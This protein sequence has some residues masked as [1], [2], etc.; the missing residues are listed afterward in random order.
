M[1]S[2]I[3]M[4]IMMMTMAMAIM[5]IIVLVVV[6]FVLA[7]V[8][9]GGA[10]RKT[11]TIF[12]TRC[13]GCRFSVASLARRARSCRRQSP[14]IRQKTF[15][16]FG[17]FVFFCFFLVGF[18]ARALRSISGQT[19]YF[20]GVWL[21]P[22][23]FLCFFALGV[24]WRFFADFFVCFRRPVFFRNFRETLYFAGVW[25]RLDFFFV[26]FCPWCFCCFFLVFF[27]VLFGAGGLPKFLL[28]LL[29]GRCCGF[30]ETFVCALC[31]WPLLAFGVVL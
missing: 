11:T 12:K 1:C 30:A 4:M 17:F 28:N 10:K 9:V 18:G 24:F 5:I 21:C 19:L 13:L 8:I 31:W 14:E 27:C 2:T 25:L 22:D 26:F 29:F 7:G 3:M 23:F 16:P 20:A 6:V 15:R